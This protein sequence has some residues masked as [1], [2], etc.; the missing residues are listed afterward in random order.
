MARVTIPEEGQADPAAF[1]WQAY[2]GRMAEAGFGFSLAV[3]KHSQLS[4]RESE[5]ARVRTA[6]INGCRIC[7]AWRGIRDTPEFLAA[8]G[9][10]GPSV[11]DNGPAPDEAFYEAIASWRGSPLFT[12]RERAALEF[13]ERMAADPQQLAVDDGFWEG[14][15][16]A[17]SDAEVTDLT[18]SVAAWMAMGRATHVLGLDQ[19]CALP[20][21]PETSR[22][23]A[24]GVV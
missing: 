3:Y 11:V 12:P 1:A 18:L 10:E 14:T 21:K 6:Q 23:E 9:Q 7:K 4:L 15:M 16:S 13:A 8:A 2:G 22:R 19:V 5:A 24:E 17:F 20:G